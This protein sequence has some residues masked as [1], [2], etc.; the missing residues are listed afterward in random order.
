M[1]VRLN[2]DYLTSINTFVKIGR[3]SQSKTKKT[4]RLLPIMLCEPR[5]L[6]QIK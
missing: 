1:T 2:A 5:A 3:K 4:L 6:F